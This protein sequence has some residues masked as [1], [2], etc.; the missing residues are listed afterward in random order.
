MRKLFLAIAILAQLSVFAQTKDLDKQD[1]EDR[2][3]YLVQVARKV[4]SGI[5][6]KYYRDWAKPL[7]SPLQ[8]F[9]EKEIG[10]RKDMKRY[11]GRK[12]YAVSILYDKSKELF[13]MDYAARVCIWA[14]DGTPWSIETGNGMGCEFLTIPFKEYVKSKDFMEIPYQQIDSDLRKYYK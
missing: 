13:E 14:D 8:S 12:Y 10:N 5:S 1:K 6:K 7:I 2:E 9:G 3:A 11:K 4:I